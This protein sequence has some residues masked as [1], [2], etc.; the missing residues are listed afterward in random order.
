VPTVALGGEVSVKVTLAGRTVRLT[1]P[2]VVSVG[3]P[4]SVAFTVRLTVPATVGVPLTTQP[5]SVSPAGRVPAVS[6]HAY[7]AVPPDTPMVAV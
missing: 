1:G 7:G 4:E 3:L 6:V 5:V 2:V